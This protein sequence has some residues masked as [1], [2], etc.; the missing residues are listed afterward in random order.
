MHGKSLPCLQDLR[1]FL[2]DIAV[3]V[4]GFLTLNAISTLRM[5]RSALLVGQIVVVVDGVV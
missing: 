1:S 5:L 4:W 2:Q 3:V